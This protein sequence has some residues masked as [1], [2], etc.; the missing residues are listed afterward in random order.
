MVGNVEWGA[1][2]VEKSN[3]NS[4]VIVEL[5]KMAVLLNGVERVNNV[6]VDLG[7]EHVEMHLNPIVAHKPKLTKEDPFL[8]PKALVEPMSFVYNSSEFT[9]AQMLSF[10]KRWLRAGPRS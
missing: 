6:I 5:Q 9:T 4:P 3:E 10:T 7:L 1:L 2:K 8:D